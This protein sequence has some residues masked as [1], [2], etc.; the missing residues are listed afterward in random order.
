MCT[1]RPY[2]F[3][4]NDLADVVAEML[5]CR[6]QAVQKG[7]KEHV[8]FSGYPENIRPPQKHH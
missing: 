6:L 3:W 2:K 1:L 4:V 8:D 5:E 7:L